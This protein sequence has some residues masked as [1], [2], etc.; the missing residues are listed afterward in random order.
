MKKL[1]RVVIVGF[2]NVGKSTLF[3]RILGKRRAL[4]HSEPG[5][6]RDSVA[7]PGSVAGKR[8]VLVDAGGLFGVEDE[9]LSNKVRDRAW[10]EALDSDIVLFV[11]DGRRDVSPAEEELH[12]SL[13][14]LDKPVL[15]V[16][17]KID[18]VTAE[19]KGTDFYR[20]GAKSLHLVS[21]EHNL[22]IGPLLEALAAA[23]PSRPDET[24]EGRPL[25]IAIVGRVNVGK[26]SLV[27]KLLG[28][29]RL[30]VSEVP[31]TT[32][33]STDTIVTRDKKAFCLVDTAGIR[34]LAGTRDSREKAGIIRAKANIRSA[35]VI[36]LLLDVQEFPTRQDAHIA[37]LAHESG[38]PLLIALNKWDL[39]DTRV[40]DAEAVRAKVRR[41]FGFVDYAPLLFVSAR[42]GQRL[43][44]I[45]DLA[46]KIHA[47]ASRRVE[48]S[49]LNQFLASL[50]GAH[51]PR[52]RGGERISLRYMTQKGVLPP[53]FIL[54]TNTGA[55]LAATYEKFFIGRLRATYDFQGTPV[56]LIVRK[57]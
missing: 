7:L 11:L 8:F 18:S 57:S 14:K 4:V 47:N 40:V 36:C 45:L 39:V 21:A 19:T 51:P 30:L 24:G 50:G 55:P 48:T 43:V 52:S 6:T 17:N 44:K 54:F 9:P 46:E 32:R 49:R 13:I 22:N 2:P 12:S 31:G 26:S 38:K 25:R 33:D 1:P 10:K 16:V 41:K 3:N 42:S 29:E 28:E 53:S 35:E 34:R 23:L 15:V 56:R 20:L 37:Q 27:N 5:M